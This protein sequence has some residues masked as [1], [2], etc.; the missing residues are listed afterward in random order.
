MSEQHR[1]IVSFVNRGGR[2]TVGQRRAWERDWA[3][4]GSELA[5][6]PP[7]DEWFGRNAP[8][9]LEIGSG[10]GEATAALAAAEPERNYLVA[11]VY[12][13]GLAQL[14]LRVEELELSNL[15]MV[16]GDA[17]ELVTEQLPADFLDGVR[18][19][20]PDPWPKKRHHKRRLIAPEFISTLAS[21]MAPGARLHL[22][23][24]WADYAEWMLEVCSGEPLL[25]NEYADYAPRPEWR[26]R[27]KF[28][29][30][31]ELEGRP[32]SDLMFTRV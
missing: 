20:Y 16:R 4:L 1:G 8:V 13:P 15:R 31:A 23:T 12:P 11:E 14:L 19:F 17:V 30:R 21:R 29:R 5:E 7:L 3:R 32:S 9:L 18:I 25:R 24:D 2:M 28:E 27:T 6:L 10:M 26:P 22:A